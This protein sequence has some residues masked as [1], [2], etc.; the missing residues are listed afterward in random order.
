M[1]NRCGGTCQWLLDEQAFLN[2]TQP[3]SSDPVLWVHG[4]PGT[5]KSMLASTI[6]DHLLHSPK[7]KDFLLLFFFV[8]G[9]SN[10][11]EKIESV[12][13]LRSLVYQLEA[14]TRLPKNDLVQK[15][16]N[17]SLKPQATSFRVLWE[18]FSALLGLLTDCTTCILIDGVDEC[19]DYHKLVSKLLSLVS[20][21]KYHIKLYF[22]SRATSEPDLSELLDF[23]SFIEITASKTRKDMD[24][25][26]ADRME[27]VIDDTDD[28]LKQELFV[29]LKES[30]NGMFV[31]VLVR[32][33]LKVFMRGV[34]VQ[35][36][37]FSQRQ[38]PQSY[39]YLRGAPGVVHERCIQ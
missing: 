37:R 39:S 27:N 17:N 32:V 3:L 14:S 36:N 5:G 4:A 13:I 31:S 1:D 22:S 7:T 35:I 8:D 30:A 6:V 19:P 23:Y 10:N 25:F 21:P 33:N 38:E 24:L 26:I 12:A 34:T 28:S 16:F 9:R 20:T 15:A 2:W 11:P 29:A 18:V